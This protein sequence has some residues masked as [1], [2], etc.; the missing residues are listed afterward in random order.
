MKKYLF[1]LILSFSFLTLWSQNEVQTVSKKLDWTKK[2]IFFQGKTTET[3]SF[4]GANWSS[5][6]PFLPQFAVS[7]PVN[8]YG[9]LEI[10][11]QNPVYEPVDFAF[12]IDEKLVASNISFNQEVRMERNNFSGI[13]RFIPIRK[14]LGGY[15]KLL[16]FELQIKLVP[17]AF[18]TVSSQR[19]G[20]TNNSVLREG[21]W[22]KI[23]VEN[24]GIQRIDAKLL[25]DAGIDITKIDAKKLKIYGNGGGML[26][27]RNAAFRYDDLEENPCVVI[28]EDDGKLND[29]DYIL[30][31]G[32]GADKWI[33]DAQNK[34]YNL[35]KNTY[36][37]TSF[38]FVRT[39]GENGKRISTQGAITQTP[40]YTTS[41]FS[42]FQR[43]EVERYNLLDEY[44]GTPGGGREWFGDKFTPSKKTIKL[45]DFVFPNI[46]KNVQINVKSAL[47]YRGKNSS[48][49][50]LSVD[51]E[52]FTAYTS[53]CGACDYDS[54]FAS[55]GSTNSNILA[56]NDNIALNVT[57]NGGDNDMESYLDFV[58]MNARRK[59]IFTGN[60]MAFRDIYSLEYGVVK[61]EL[62]NATN[63][64]ALW[65]ISNP[66]APKRLEFTLSGNN[67][68]FNSLA[69]S[70]LPKEFVIFN[71]SSDLNK[72][73]LVGKM[74]NQ[75]LHAISDVD[76][77]L[78]YPR[79][80]EKDALRLASYRKSNGLKVVPVPIDEV[81]NEFS[82]GAIDPTAIRDFTKFLYEK[83]PKF[84]YLLL[85]GDGSFNYKN[86][87]VSAEEAAKNF[88]PPY[89]TRESLDPL[90]TFP[91]DDYYGLL[92]PLEGGN[93]SDNGALEISVGRITASDEDMAKAIVDKIISYDK[94]PDA[95]RDYRNR[96]L[97]IAD[98][99]EV[100]GDS[101]EMGFLTHSET[102]SEY[103]EK[104]YKKMNIEKAYLSA[105]PQITTAGGQRSPATTEAINNNIFKGALFLNYTGHG[106]PRGWAQERI[107]NANT[108]VANWSNFDRLPLFITATC[109][110]AGYDSPG[111][112]TAGE[113]IL[114]LDKGGA[115]ALFS[116]VRPVYGTDNDNLTDALFREIYKKIGYNGLSIGEVL[117]AGKNNANANAENNRKFTLMGDPSQRLM[118]PQYDIRTTKIN[119]KD[120]TSTSVDTVG[121]LQKVAVE[122]T[123]TDSLGNVLTNFNGKVYPTIYD[124]A[125]TLKTVPI[126]DQNTVQNYR[127]QNK[128]LFKGAATV[129]NGKFQFSCIIPKDI[130]Y[131]YGLGKISYYATNNVNDAAGYDV[132]HLVIGGVSKNAE[133]DDKGPLVEVFMDNEEFVLGGIVSFNPT[134]V[135]RLSDDYGIN[136]SGNSVGHDLTAVLDDNTQK[137]FRLNDFYEAAVDN[138]AKGGVKYPLF[139]LT[140]GTHQIRVKAW[141]TANNPGEG[142]TEFVVAANGKTALEHVLNYPNPFTT[143][144][145]FQFRHHLAEI[146]LKVQ[147]QV[148]TVAGRLVKTIET[149]ALSQG[150]VVDD[151]NWDG[152]DDFGNDLAKGVYIYKIK[153]RSTRNASIQ[154]EGAFEKMVILK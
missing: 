142:V 133:K 15:E 127:L 130:N 136:V 143:N 123:V 122:G 8:R 82:S 84:E 45:N 30:F 146:N 89:E 42:D 105:F 59:S 139:K 25:K 36:S 61:Y 83:N 121:A 145:N 10:S 124:K 114:A 77:L 87:G 27:E 126:G 129:K 102:L 149:D 4:Q 39:D 33:F 150:S 79:A 2:Q 108:D 1:T 86:T 20:P 46:E 5:Q 58:Q 107:L 6:T 88:I 31:Y 41:S 147:V 80:L 104:N 115:M 112:F 19:G 95:M 74:N 65:E 113:Q 81:Y 76:M 63:A 29:G 109:S 138:P 68:T 23:A 144:T 140:E 70:I 50:T 120:V 134:V 110:F 91:S 98:D 73:V 119:G 117:R 22:V 96:I 14:T 47:A 132:T 116:T 71:P 85:F 90:R 141:D 24:T 118:I 66:V 49:Y 128:I 52:D 97:F 17:K 53:S 57:V 100:S 16:R 40:N 18:P 12:P 55:V 78:L 21:T 35:E 135:V 26:P 62:S 11:M 153:I 38:Y 44:T 148:F 56:Q 67:A 131:D 101:F 7:V 99:F 103:T 106:G 125:L 48:S 137:T 28:G 13:V 32:A 54:P 151:V 92:S 75:N 93:I 37:T 60:Q 3:W 43:Y 154:E 69:D 152:K 9:T 34:V 94:S 111:D 51:N 64:L 72:P